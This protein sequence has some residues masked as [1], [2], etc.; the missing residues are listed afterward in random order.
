M[1]KIGIITWYWGNYGSI[2]QAYAMQQ[3]LSM[4]G[5]DCEVVQHHV[6]GDLK[7]Q[8]RYR[9]SHDSPLSNLSNI[10]NKFSKRSFLPFAAA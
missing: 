1:K 8:A 9:L 7:M 10:K 2:L 5:Y 3:Y 6:N 4:Q